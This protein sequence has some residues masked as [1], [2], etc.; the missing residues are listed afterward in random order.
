MGAML[1]SSCCI[2]R[3]ISWAVLGTLVE[4]QRALACTWKGVSGTTVG[5]KSSASTDTMG[6]D[7][8][9]PVK[10]LQ[11]TTLER[12]ENGLAA[13]E[14]TVGRQ[15]AREALPMHTA[16]KP[17]RSGSSVGEKF[18]RSMLGGS[19]LVLPST[20]T[21]TSCCFI[22]SNRSGLDLLEPIQTSVPVLALFA[23]HLLFAMTYAGERT[24]NCGSAEV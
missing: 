20:H 8:S 10:L 3:G 18:S 22:S 12:L 11:S 21:M 17:M 4:R 13:Q 1:L 2:A 6:Q 14:L 7:K 16:C 19:P 23:R 9:G 15:L 5:E 24:L